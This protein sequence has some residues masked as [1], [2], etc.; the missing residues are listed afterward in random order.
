MK[1]A[2]FGFVCCLAALGMASPL[3]SADDNPPQTPEQKAWEL[4]NSFDA[5]SVGD[6]LKQFPAGELAAQAKVALELQSRL[7]KIR[8]GKSKGDFVIPFAAF[9]NTWKEWQ[10][11]RPDRG[12][13]GYFAASQGNYST[14]GW[15]SPAPMSGGKTPGAN[16]MSFDSNGI[17]ISPTGDGSIIAFRTQ[18]L[19]LELLQGVI[20]QT[21]GDEP[22]YFAVV[23]KKGLVHLKGQGSVTLP[24]KKTTILK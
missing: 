10:Q 11:T 21:P 3:W 24:N 23:A 19:K 7:A 8:A 9:G 18:G 2:V 12:V 5:Q 4:V 6:F 13:V 20:F 17:L 1:K 16:E 15:F 14:L 22:M